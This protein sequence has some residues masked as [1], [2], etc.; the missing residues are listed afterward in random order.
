MNEEQILTPLQYR[1]ANGCGR[2]VWNCIGEENFW[3]QQTVARILRDERYTGKA[4]YGRQ[5]REN[6]SPQT[7][8]IQAL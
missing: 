4:V 5:K 3:T 2:T 7:M 6:G 8:H 1:R